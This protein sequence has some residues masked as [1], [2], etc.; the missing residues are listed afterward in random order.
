[1]HLASSTFACCLLAAACSGH[2]AAPHSTTTTTANQKA[3]TMTNRDKVVALLESLETGA[4]EPVAFINPNKYI[5]HNL[6]A[7]D[8]LAGF[9]ALL[10][11]KPPQG[12][13]AKVVRAFED[14]DFVFAHTEYDFFGPKIGFDIFR[15]ENG[16]IVEHWDNLQ[17]TVAK[18]P[19]GHTM[20][21]GPVAASDLDKTG[22]NKELVRTFVNDVLVGE[23]YGRIGEFISATEYAQHNPLVPDGLQGLTK[24]LGDL[25]AKGVFMKYTKLHQLLGSGNFVLAVSEG[26]FGGKATSYYDL[27]RVAGGKLVEHWDVIEEIPA[28]ADWKNQ[29]GKF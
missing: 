14:G 22:S 19:S 6:G 10:A 17:T 21:D 15:F 20:I 29:N 4:G 8:G 24:T 26:N 5:Q 25:A 13:K 18:T 16:L 11:Q 1:M 28:K 12:F 7:A 27:F 23:A 3:N 2:R 9:G